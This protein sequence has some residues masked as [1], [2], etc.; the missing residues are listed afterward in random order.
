MPRSRAAVCL[1]LAILMGVGLAGPAEASDGTNPFQE[2]DERAARER[3]KR[4]AAKVEPERPLLPSMGGAG[5][6]PWRPDAGLG[7]P[8]TP[9]DPRASATDPRAE[10]VD[11]QPLATP[12]ERSRSV[13][14]AD[15][16]PVLTS[17]G[18]GLPLEFWQGLDAKGVEELV[19]RLEIPPRSAA[20]H[21]LWKRL[22][23]SSAT[24]PAGGEAGAHFEA[25][26]VEALYR[27]GLLA[28][29]AQR[30]KDG[31]GATAP[32]LAAL[33]ARIGIGAGNR[34]QGCADA[35][36]VAKS[37]AEIPKPVRGEMLLLSGYCAASEGDAAAA[38]LAADLARA[39][40]F[41]APL[42][43]AALDAAVAGQ[44]FK[45]ALPRR[46]SLVEY[47]FLELAKSIAPADALERAEPAL[48]VALATSEGTNAATRLAA[49][50][51]AARINALTPEAL[52]AAY[53]AHAA[54]DTGAGDPLTGR[55]AESTPPNR[56][57]S[58]P[59]NLVGSDPAFRRAALFKAVEA[60]RTPIRKARLART[61]LDEA[62]RA[63]LYWPVAQLLAGPIGELA[64]A[65][66]IGWFAETA[67]E[68]NLAAGRNEAART[69][70][71]FAAQDRGGSGLEHWLALIDI[72]DPKWP[73]PRG[74]ALV[75]VEQIAVRGRL[76]SDL[77]HRLA[78]VLDALDYQ[79]PIPLWEAAS[80][81]PQPGTGHLPETGVLK[82][83]QDAAKRREFA[84][85]VL[86]AIRTLG[87]T[88]ADA[89]HVI[90]L[91]DAIRALKRAGLEADARRLGLEAVFAA[92]PRMASQ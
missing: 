77:L 50:E 71:G 16:Q 78:T 12:D 53:R 27:S 37:R 4:P 87:A 10:P 3:A 42:A 68:I 58:T 25:L 91:G 90:A 48:L 56:A 62:R 84:R 41:Q 11:R 7:A 73:G 92:W 34:E 38:G 76:P 75:H 85:T 63:G 59:P 44:A 39:E 18:S 2:R 9:V 47:R 14:R 33:N 51:M 66:E 6:Q 31:T 24:P 35:R 83:L 30:Q 67:I 19:A 46:L 20:L 54:K 23:T 52:A 74:A 22:W 80:R 49:A 45:P 88:G 40:E 29:I 15:L 64:A 21:G 5:T 57:E 61:L 79:V 69:W 13:E 36:S 60:E 89:A 43:L 81:T 32:L 70:A 55:R 65:Q 82:D 72:A 8:A 26:R 1:S 86:L 28:E 17:D